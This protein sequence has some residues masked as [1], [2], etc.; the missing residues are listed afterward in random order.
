MIIERCRSLA[1][2]AQKRKMSKIA[3][4]LKKVCYKVFLCVKTVSDIVVT[5]KAFIGRTIR[6][7]MIGGDEP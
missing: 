6:T 1:K 3:L 4:R 2:V 7:R 5:C